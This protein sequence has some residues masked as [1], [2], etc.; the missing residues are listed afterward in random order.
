MMELAAHS[1]RDEDEDEEYV[2][3]AGK[4]KQDDDL[5]GFRYSMDVS[6]MYIGVE[7]DKLICERICQNPPHT[8]TMAKNVFHHQ[9]IDSSH[10]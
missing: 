8:H 2:M 6:C 5:G 10:Q 9:L 3:V 1:N 4:A 7:D